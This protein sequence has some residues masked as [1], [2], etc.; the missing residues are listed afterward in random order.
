MDK[1][2]KITFI[3]NNKNKPEAE[4][5]LG[6]RTMSVRSWANPGCLRLFL[7][8][9][10]DHPFHVEDVTSI[11]VLFDEDEGKGKSKG[12]K[13]KPQDKKAKKE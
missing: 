2:K 3:Y 11:Q 12:E 13:K 9:G 5:D 10:R 1:N 6:E 4:R 7:V 8:E